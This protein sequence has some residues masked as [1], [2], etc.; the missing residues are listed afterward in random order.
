MVEMNLSTK[1][2]RNFYN[3]AM[4][5]EGYSL[6]DVY[7]TC[8]IEKRKSYNDCISMFCETEESTY[9]HICS[10]NI[11]Q[12]SCAWLGKKDGENILR[13]ETATNSYLVW[14]DR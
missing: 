13:M 9:F 7:N 14:L 1:R 12:Y 8:S 6:E 3:R 2:G 4:R 10:H 5:N 11:F